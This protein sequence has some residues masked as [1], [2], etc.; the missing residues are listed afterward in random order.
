MRSVPPA[1]L[2]WLYLILTAAFLLGAVSVASAQDAAAKEKP[3][4]AFQNDAGL[5]IFYV[6]PDKTADF[7]EL[8][9]KLKDGLSKVE[10]PEA[11]QML[12]GMKLF[13]TPVAAGA[14][15]ASYVLFADPV[16]KNTEYLAPNAALQG[17]SGGSPG[18]LSEVAGREGRHAGAAVDPGPDTGHQVPVAPGRARRSQTAG[19]ATS[20]P[21]RFPVCARHGAMAPIPG[22]VQPIAKA[23]WEV[24]GRCKS[25]GGL[26]DRNP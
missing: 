11:K 25:S 13:K 22:A 2:V 17:V 14:Q 26:D 23:I 5:I 24:T 16:V 3:T 8:M 6:K 20:A 9:T 19:E 21:P 7:E 4:L 10:A 18:A 1:C 12:A 15:V